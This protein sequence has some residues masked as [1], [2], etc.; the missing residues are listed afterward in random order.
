MMASRNSLAAAGGSIATSLTL[1]LMGKH[2]DALFVG[3]WGFKKKGMGDAEYE[4]LAPRLD[5]RLAALHVLEPLRQVRLQLGPGGIAREVDDEQRPERV[6]EGEAGGFTVVQQAANQ[7][8]AS[9]PGLANGYVPAG[10]ALI[11]TTTPRNRVGG[12]LALAQAGASTGTLIGP[13]VGAALVGTLPSMHALFSFTGI[14][15]FVA[16]ALALFLVRERHSRCAVCTNSRTVGAVP[17]A[18]VPS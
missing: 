14:A 10:Q 9:R 3:Q 7:V 16:A 18:V 13:V 15:M 5:M 11:A 17:E 12:A 6:V 1:K 2:Q 4:R 8:A